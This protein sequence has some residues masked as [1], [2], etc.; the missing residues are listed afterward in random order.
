MTDTEQRLAEMEQMNL[1]EKTGEQRHGKA[2]WR[3][4]E[5]ARQLDPEALDRLVKRGPVRAHDA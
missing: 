1:V 2:V 4:T 5:R 3:M